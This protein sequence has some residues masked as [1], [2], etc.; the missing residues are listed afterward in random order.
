MAVLIL[1]VGLYH[2][3]L[4]LSKTLLFGLTLLGLMHILGGNV[5]LFGVRLYDLWL[6]PEI[7]KYDN[8]VHGFG[9]FLATLVAYNLLRPHLDVKMK[10][11]PYFLSLILI[12]IAMGIGAFNEVLELGAV[13]FLNAGSGVGDYINNAFDLFFNLIGS[14]I[15]CV[16]IIRYH[17]KNA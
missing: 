17:L 11:N 4:H 15:A 9:I 7:F 2:K 14:V 3:K 8:L 6:I 12:L 10:H 13:L 1:I 16:F 5:H